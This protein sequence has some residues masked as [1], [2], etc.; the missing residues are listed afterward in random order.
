[1]KK[2]VPAWLVI[3]LVLSAVVGTTLALTIKALTIEKINIWGGQIQ[4]TNFDIIEIDTKIKGPNKIDISI[5][6]RNTDAA[7]HSARVTLQLL[8]DNDNVIVEATQL[9]GDVAGGATW[10]YTFSFSQ[11]GLV[12]EYNRPFLVVKQLS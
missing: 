2:A 9:T 5:T 11:Q 3:V 6:L 10:T 4:D 7:T 8:D 1:M 12:S